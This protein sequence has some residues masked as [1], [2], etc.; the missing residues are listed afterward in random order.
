[1]RDD[2]GDS[3][4]PFAVMRSPDKETLETRQALLPSVPFPIHC[5][6]LTPQVMRIG[7]ACR[8]PVSKRMECSKNPAKPWHAEGWR[9]GRRIGRNPTR[10]PGSIPAPRRIPHLHVAGARS[11]PPAATVLLLL[12]RLRIIMS[13][14]SCVT[15][16]RARWGPGDHDIQSRRKRYALSPGSEPWPSIRRGPKTRSA[17]APSRSCMRYPGSSEPP[18]KAAP[19]RPGQSSARSRSVGPWQR[20]ARAPPPTQ[21]DLT[22][23]IGGEVAGAGIGRTALYTGRGT[24]GS[25]RT[26]G[27]ARSPGASGPG[28]ELFVC[29]AATLDMYGTAVELGTK[30]H[31]KT[32]FG[33]DTKASHPFPPSHTWGMCKSQELAFALCRATRT[34]GASSAARTS[35]R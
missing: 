27:S 28:L 35:P 2:T 14:H 16:R 29:L 10:R 24:S 18:G 19:S 34:R 8:F 32:L 11:L 13:I 6:A 3:Q 12:E 17:R 4:K 31:P 5:L 20:N 23:L 25:P 9:R 33:V 15:Y 7:G 26:A 1:M 21:I 30:V 22:S